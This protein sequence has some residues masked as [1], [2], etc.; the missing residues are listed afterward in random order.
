MTYIFSPISSPSGVSTQ[1]VDCTNKLKPL[2]LLSSITVVSQ[3]TTGVTIDNAAIN[4]V[5][6]TKDDG[7]SKIDIKKGFT[8]DVTS[9][10]KQIANI[11]I[12]V[13]WTGDDGTI[14]SATISQPVVISST[15]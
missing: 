8:F 3:D 2:E 6:L 5:V 13:T 1:Q 11:P 9:V 15:A 7:V 10:R 14:G 4:T 12:K